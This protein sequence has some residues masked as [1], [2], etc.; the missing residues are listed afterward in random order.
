MKQWQT[1]AAVGSVLLVAAVLMMS[2]ET[3]SLDFAIYRS[4]GSETVSQHA[5]YVCVFSFLVFALFAL[6]S[7]LRV[8]FLCIL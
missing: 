4:S 7:M 8:F 1:V 6:F 3:Q 5:V 2:S